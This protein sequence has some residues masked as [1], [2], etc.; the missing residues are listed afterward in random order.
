MISIFGIRI[1][2]QNK[3]TKILNAYLSF[4]VPTYPY[5]FG[6]EVKDA[7]TKNVKKK[8]ILKF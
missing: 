1:E 7:Y 3:Q 4:M 5:T 2:I 8:P 6:T